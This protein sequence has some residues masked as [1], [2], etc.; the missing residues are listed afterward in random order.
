MIINKSNDTNGSEYYT[1]DT[2]EYFFS[3]ELSDYIDCRYKLCMYVKKAC[4]S[5]R[6]EAKSN[7]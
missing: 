7:V 4:G 3:S 5:I 1:S 2:A 6:G